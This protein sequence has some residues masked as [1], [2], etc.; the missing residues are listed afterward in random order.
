MEKNSSTYNNKRFAQRTKFY[1]DYDRDTSIPEPGARLQN[2]ADFAGI[3]FFAKNMSP[4]ATKQFYYPK[5]ISNAQ[6]FLNN[7]I[8]D[9]D[10]KNEMKKFIS[11]MVML[12]DNK[13]VEE[14]DAPK[15][16]WLQKNTNKVEQYN[17]F[18]NWSQSERD[19]YSKRFDA[20][21]NSP[22]GVFLQKA[23]IAL[24]NAEIAAAK[25]SFPE[26]FAVK[27]AKYMSD[28]APGETEPT[29]VEPTKR[30]NKP[31][32][33]DSSPSNVSREP[34]P[35]K[36]EKPKYNYSYIKSIKAIDTPNALVYYAAKKALGLKEVTDINS[37]YTKDNYKTIAAEIAKIADS[38]Y[39]N[40][41]NRS[42][43]KFKDLALDVLFDKTGGLGLEDK[44]N[45]SD[46]ASDDKK[47]VEDNKAGSMQIKTQDGETSLES[48]VQTEAGDKIRHLLEIVEDKD[49]PIDQLASIWRNLRV[50]IV[51]LLNNSQL[52]TE[53]RVEFETRLKNIDY[54]YNL[55]F[56]PQGG[57]QLKNGKFVAYTSDRLAELLL[58][59]LAAKD[60]T[61][62]NDYIGKLKILFAENPNYVPDQELRVKLKIKI[63]QYNARN[64]DNQVEKL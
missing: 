47:P 48:S 21:K 41:L 8:F 64:P 37:Y 38:P 57:Q 56:N 60:V 4:E 15:K 54:R 22:R 26:N 36:P 25:F 2:W 7:S 32:N 20:M 24:K 62:A 40:K 5:S 61:T 34:V 13:T 9:N 63:N 18:T 55:A 6:A 10:F 16:N 31:Q 28:A 58:G 49:L 17:E 33:V 1:E 35:Q 39:L 59:A 45:T 50:Q 51:N 43:K 19:K 52:E 46:S 44:I 29:K 42:L 23:L 27:G 12:N 53:E 11:Y 3:N 14:I 30:E